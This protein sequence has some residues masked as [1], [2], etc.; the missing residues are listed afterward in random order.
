MSELS[1]QDISDK[2]NRSLSSVKE[3]LKD[4]VPVRVTNTNK[5]YFS[6]EQFSVLLDELKYNYGH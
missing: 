5:Y 4:Y 1:F 3:L 6:A 2:L